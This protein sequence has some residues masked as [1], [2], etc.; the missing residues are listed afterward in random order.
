MQRRG[1]RRLTAIAQ[2][3]FETEFK[4]GLRYQAQQIVGALRGAQP[5]LA[6]LGEA[7]RSMALCADIYGLRSSGAA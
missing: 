1:E 6:T 5:D 4:P 2:D 3:V 7:A